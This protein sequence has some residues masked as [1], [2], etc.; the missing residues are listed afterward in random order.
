MGTVTV[1]NL[2]IG[3][4]IPK[5][6][7]PLVSPTRDGILEEARGIL[8]LPYDL[9]EWRCDWYE[10][11][12]TKGTSQVLTDLREILGDSPI[13]CT[14]RTKE[15]G[16][17]REASREQYLDLLH[18]ILSDGL[19][20][21]IDLELF[22]L[23]DALGELIASAKSRGIK[24]IVSNHDFQHTPPKEE[25]LR[26]FQ[27]MRDAG[28]D[29]AKVAAM[30]ENSEDVLNLLYAAQEFSRNPENIPVIAMSMGSLGCVSRICGQAFGSSVT[31]GCAQKA[32]APGQFPARELKMIMTLLEE[33]S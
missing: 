30:P 2:T 32:S 8:S 22:T 21:L 5:I 16:G 3:Q 19:A 14:F 6:C 26:R 13:L 23:G 27:M 1:R 18:Q 29:I 31:F 17:A 11:I 28:A 33:D 9:V 25:I 10:D 7:I 12:F 15:E 4:G 20:D 24:T